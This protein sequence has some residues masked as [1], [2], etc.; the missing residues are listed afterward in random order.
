MKSKR[1]ALNTILT[2]FLDPRST[3]PC[4]L[5]VHPDPVRLE[6]VAT[7]LHAE[8]DW[9]RF[10]VGCMLSAALL[11]VTP[12]AR[13]R[14]AADY[15]MDSLRA[16]APGPVLCTEVD[17]LFEPDLELNPLMLCCRIARWTR[18]IVFWPGGYQ[19]GVLTYAVPGHAR[20]RHWRNPEV[21]VEIIE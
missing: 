10:S 3:R 18:L 5:L 7:F 9:P 4:L 14:K 2:T 21:W 1:Q 13:P 19:Q 8:H 6:D 20:Y 16:R 17:L 15:W 11:P 12:K